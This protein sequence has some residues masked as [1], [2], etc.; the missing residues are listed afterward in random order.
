MGT[1]T[2]SLYSLLPGLIPRH[3][4]CS[5]PQDGLSPPVILFSLWGK[6][7]YSQKACS[8]TQ[9]AGP[10]DSCLSSF[11]PKTSAVLMPGTGPVSLGLC[12]FLHLSAFLSFSI[13]HT[14][15]RTHRDTHTYA[16]TH[17]HTHIHAHTQTPSKS[18][19]IILGDNIIQK[20]I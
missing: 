17:M 15:R 11:H 13:T 8:D 7:D 9:S 10:K 20:H 5:E 12:L 6:C 19:Q 3:T 2:L 18:L 16:R 1:L 4:Y 14:H